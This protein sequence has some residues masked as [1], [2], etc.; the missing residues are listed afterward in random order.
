MKR[1]G[2]DNVPRSTIVRRRHLRKRRAALPAPRRSAF[3]RLARG[4]EQKKTPPEFAAELARAQ[5]QG[6][7]ELNSEAE[8]GASPHRE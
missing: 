4:S 8:A 5:E 1:A 2:A 7:A 3:A 6:T